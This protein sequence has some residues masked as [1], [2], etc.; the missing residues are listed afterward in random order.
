MKGNC[1]QFKD[2]KNSY[3]DV[4]NVNF[5]QAGVFSISF[6]AR[7]TKKPTKN[8]LMTIFGNAIGRDA[9]G[10]FVGSDSRVVQYQEAVLWFCF[11]QTRLALSPARRL[12]ISLLMVQFQMHFTN[13]HRHAKHTIL[14]R[15]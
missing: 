15:A 8:A 7:T 9:E 3:V 12:L 6:W 1:I 13:L 2:S 5:M 11:C 14:E 10:V 4:G